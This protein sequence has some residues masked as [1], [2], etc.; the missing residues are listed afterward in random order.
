MR[1]AAALAVLWLLP[2]AGAIVVYQQLPSEHEVLSQ[3]ATPVFALVA[4][5]TD[6]ATQPGRLTFDWTTPTTIVSDMSGVVTA[7]FLQPGMKLTEGSP[8]VAID[9]VVR[10][11]HAGTT[12]FYRPITAGLTG[13]DVNEL[14]RYLQDLGVVTEPTLDS[15]GRATRATM[16]AVDS[17]HA[18]LGAQ[19]RTPFLPTD[20]IFLP[21]S[22]GAVGAIH[23]KVG[24]DL[25]IGAALFEETAA[26]TKLTIEPLGQGDRPAIL[27]SGGKISATLPS[28]VHLAVSSLEV[29]TSGELEELAELI[30]NDNTIKESDG[31]VRLVEPITF[32]SV[33][34]SALLPKGSELCLLLGSAMGALTA[35]PPKSVIDASREVG[36][37]YVD[38]SLVGKSYL[39]NPRP[40]DNTECA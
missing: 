31:V 24:D 8:V 16:L 39:V 34:S 1:F 29:T 4:G 11:A 18:F 30:S 28:G 10:L 38:H 19:S 15:R 23:V 5:R 25:Q 12:P 7:T 17:L 20:V 27:R 32:G 40:D 6:D 33:S 3:P 2:V 21:S 36:I 26:L 35:A 13:P 37:T 14:D 22:L 9:G